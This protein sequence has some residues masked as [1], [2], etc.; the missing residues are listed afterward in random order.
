MYT[1]NDTDAIYKLDEKSKHSEKKNNN[2]RQ[3]QAEPT[4]NNT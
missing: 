4:T 1:N 2:N 3:R